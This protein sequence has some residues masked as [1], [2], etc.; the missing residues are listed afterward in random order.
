MSELVRE[1]LGRLVQ[2]LNVSSICRSNEGNRTFSTSSRRTF[3]ADLTEFAATFAELQPLVDKV[4][5]HSEENGTR[6]G[7]CRSR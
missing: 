5:R 2:I 4:W 7:P 6:G 1:A 3:V